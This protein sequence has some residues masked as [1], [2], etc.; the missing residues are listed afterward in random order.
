[1]PGGGYALPGQGCAQYHRLASPINVGL[2]SAAP[3]GM[4]LIIYP[5][6]RDTPGRFMPDDYTS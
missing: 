6:A 2:I 5:T 1:M 3:S 4:G